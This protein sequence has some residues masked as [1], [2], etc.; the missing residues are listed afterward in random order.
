MSLV[1][2]TICIIFFD[3]WELNNPPLFLPLP[4]Y[5]Q[6]ATALRKGGLLTYLTHLILFMYSNNME[7]LN[8][9]Y[10]Y[11]EVCQWLNR[12]LNVGHPKGH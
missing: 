4:V 1:Q 8:F 10:Y 12:S 6:G 9:K 2:R 3:E 7:Y 11:S 5:L